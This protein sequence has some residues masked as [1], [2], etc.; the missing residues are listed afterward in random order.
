MAG[1]NVTLRADP[2]LRLK[3]YEEALKFYLAHHGGQIHGI[4][5][6]ENSG[7]D[8]SSLKQ[9]ADS[10]NPAKIPVHFFSALSDCPPEYGKGHSELTLMDRAYDTFVKDE[11]ESTRFWKITGRLQILN[12][13]RLIARAPA[14]AEL[15][16][17]LRF[18]P[19]P[20]R[21]FGTDRWAETRIIGFTAKGYRLHLLNKR[22]IVGTPDHEFVVERALFPGLMQALERGDRI[23]PRFNLQPI[24]VG[25]GAESLKDYNDM[26]SR[27]KN[28]VRRFTRRFVPSLWL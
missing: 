10:D 15:Y 18:V 11:P 3:D 14:S 7:A 24:M 22:Q 20:L 8:L 13:G 23:T 28:M 17:D 9:I 25:I 2:A 1:A 4:L 19:R 5:F 26:P 27:I 12:I 16:L 21:F 6:C